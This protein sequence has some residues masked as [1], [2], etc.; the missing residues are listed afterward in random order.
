MT[1][2]N[3][4]IA[5][6]ASVR[7]PTVMRFCRSVGCEGVRDFRLQLARTLAV[8]E[9]FL[10]QSAPQSGPGGTPPHGTSILSK[11]HGALHEVERQLSAVQVFA[12]ADA[13]AEAA[14]AQPSGSADRRERWP[15]RRRSG[16]FVTAS[17]SSPAASRTWRE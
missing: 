3:G 5:T 6:R 8:G 15:K 2:S 10:V 7:Q 13:L 11:A 16:S 4:E 17:R 14:R 1:A 12:A 9:A